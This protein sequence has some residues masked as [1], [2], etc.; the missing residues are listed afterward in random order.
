MKKR[1]L[2]PALLLTGL[3][4]AQTIHPDYQ[5]G[6]IWFQ[7][8]KDY[9]INLPLKDNPN[10][11]PVAELPFLEKVAEKHPLTKLSRPFF[12]AKNSELLQRT[13][14]LSFSDY[15]QVDQIIAE[16]RAS[17][18]VEYAERVPLVRTTL[19]PNDPSYSGQWHLSVINAA[20]AW[21]YFSTGSTIKIAI[22]DDALE[23][24]HP[25]LS[26]NL[27]TNPGEI[28]NNGV[29]DDGN[30]YIDDINGYDVSDNDNNP[31]P[32]SSSYSH[33]THVAGCASASTNNNTG[34]AAIGYSC[35]LIAVK[36]T[37]SSSS[38]TDGYPGIVYAVAAGAD[39]I[40]MSWG[41]A[42]SSQ[43]AQNIITW[44]SQQGVVLIAAAG[45]SNVNTQFYPAAYTECIAVAA[46]SSNDAKASFSNYGSWID[47]A[48]PGNNIYSTYYNATYA[49]NSGTSMASPIV[50]G[51][52]GLMLSLN[53]SLTPADIRNC[54]TSTADNIDAQN[55]SYIGQ[56]GAGRIN[57]AAAMQCI[58]STLSWPPVAGFTA[59][60]TTITAGGNVQFTDQ[61][62]YNPT[63]WSWTF[64]GGTPASYNG[65][66]PPPIVYNTPGTYNVSLTVTNANG[67]DTQTNNAYITVTAASGCTEIN[68]PAPSGWTPVNY[69][70]G[71]SVGQDGWINGVNVNLDKEK[72]MYFDASSS[73]YTQLVNVYVGFGL[74]YSAN[75]N[76]IVNM[77]IYDGTAGPTS[78]PGAQI[79]SVVGVNMG[80]IM[81]D[82]NGNYYTEYSFVN[83]PVTLPG[84]KRFFV[85]LD[86]T[87]LQWQSSP[88]VHDT[89]SIV[90]NTNGQTTAPVPIWEKQSNNTWYQYGTVGSWNLAASLYIHPFL[91]GVNSV[92]TFTQNNTSICE[93]GTIN[94]DATGSTYDDTLLWYFPG[95]SPVISNTIQQSV[96]YNTP[97]NYQA[98]LYIVGGGC[99][100]FDSAFV[101]ITVNAA[102]N[103]TVAGSPSTSICQGGTVNL[104]AGGANTY[105]WSPGTFLNNTTG[106]S[107]ISTPTSSITYNVQGTAANGCTNDV[108]I[109]IDVNDPPQAI[110][111]VSDTTAC[112]YQSI[113]F[114][115]SNSTSAGSFNWSFPGGTP[116]TSSV[117]SPS[118]QYPAAGTYTATL[119]VSNSCGADT[120]SFANMQVGCVG[121]G[122][123]S[124]A[125]TVSSVYD[126]NASQLLLNF[127]R[128]T[129]GGK[130][131]VRVMDASGRLVLQEQVT[132]NGSRGQH[133]LPAAGLAQGI[134]S[135][136]VSGADVNY[137]N[138]FMLR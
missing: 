28:A 111:S 43:T 100:L 7:V 8:K 123:N 58:S 64:T 15:A 9:R 74:A 135:V 18:K 60:V 96:I 23:R 52:A 125:N 45:N 42:G 4:S 31:N 68:L 72:A 65:Q 33:G 80:Q 75:P 39:V 129:A 49:N 124:A 95:G 17:G 78:A 1:L 35:K 12:A 86:L 66:N 73:P 103:V 40:N 109:N 54:L 11:V 126:A 90:S 22:V 138:K 118:V 44:A 71:S 37:N 105:V 85:S 89:L 70:T 117:S 87:N 79:G 26:G 114:D 29:D 61:S 137:T 91:T 94:F 97:G 119:I 81:S 27:W 88:S 93:G 77:K 127:E 57:A 92:A 108:T 82:V 59:N 14:Q 46:T 99:H 98:I 25:D 113:V 110:F 116:S 34:V 84:S 24:T 56:L 115:G 107:V 133:V 32:P 102:P 106:A 51:L 136:Q 120:I 19:T 16:L 30:G 63:S 134:Y 21:N 130:Y 67:N 41:G 53:P 20:T 83:S 47:I 36:S 69:Y 62:V 3:M 55:P 38:I 5:D 128:M 13:Y 122:E 132:V 76:K 6:R 2:I 50:A 48:S 10:Q 121:I 112:E 101:N 104:T 131:Q